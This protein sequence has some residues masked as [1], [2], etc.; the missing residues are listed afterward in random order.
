MHKGIRFVATGL[1]AFSLVGFSGQ[2][3]GQEKLESVEHSQKQLFFTQKELPPNLTPKREQTEVKTA[4]TEVTTPPKPKPK[5]QPNY[6]ELTVEA[7]AYVSFCDTG[8]IGI[9]KGGSDVK[10][11]ITHDETGLRIVAV[12][13]SV[14]PLGSIVEIDG[15]K[16][17]ADDIGSAIQ[18]HEIDILVDPTNTTIANNYGRQ[19]I[20]IK[21]FNRP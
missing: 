8:C 9:T 16:F 13:P 14:I 2:T 7:T 4:S 21:V 15:E 1:L 19:T 17:I 6:K 3:V 20:T 18:G 11:D 10:N 5:P 12:D